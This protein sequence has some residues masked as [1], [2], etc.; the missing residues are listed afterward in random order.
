[1]WSNGCGEE[2][3][4]VEEDE[5]VRLMMKAPKGRRQSEFCLMLAINSDPSWVVF[6]FFFSFSDI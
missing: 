2:G 5:Q 3:R 1:M 6:V 4:G